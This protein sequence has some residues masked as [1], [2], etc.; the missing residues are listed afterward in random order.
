MAKAGDRFGFI[1][2]STN[3]PNDIGMTQDGTK[4]IDWLFG[5]KIFGFPKP[6]AL[7]KCLV[8]MA[9]VISKDDSDIILDFGVV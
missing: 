9:T 1:P 7:I 6:I 3:L 4:D 8:K 5:Q 2:V